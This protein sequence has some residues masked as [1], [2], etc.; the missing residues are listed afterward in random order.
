MNVYKASLQR[1]SKSKR[2]VLTSDEEDGSGTEAIRDRKLQ[3]RQRTTLE[4][5]QEHR[6]AQ[7]ELNAGDGL[8]DEEMV[9]DK[10]ASNEVDELDDWDHDA[11][12]ESGASIIVSIV[13]AYLIFLKILPQD[14][15]HFLKH[16][17]LYRHPILIVLL[18]M[19]V[20]TLS[21]V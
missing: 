13:N 10:D 8:E 18:W 21:H 9:T 2:P 1:K 15:Y 5:H 16:P 7:H 12:K 11:E 14:R 4:S 19:S 6:V 3:A 17:V 20:Q